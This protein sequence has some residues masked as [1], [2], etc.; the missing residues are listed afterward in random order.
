MISYGK[1]N[2]P[3]GTLIRVSG[4][5]RSFLCVILNSWMI[6]STQRMYKLVHQNGG[7]F[8]SYE[9]EFWDVIL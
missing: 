8:E 2:L 9:S 6:N 4:W 5:G 3:N 1:R 7:V